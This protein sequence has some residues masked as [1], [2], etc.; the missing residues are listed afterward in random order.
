MKINAVV[1]AAILSASLSAAPQTQNTSLLRKAHEAYTAAQSLESELNE[2]PEG[3]RARADYLNVINAY[4]RVYLITPRTGYADNSLMNMARL[5]E[6]MHDNAAAIKTLKYLVHEYPSTPFKDT[7]E[8]DI[9]RLSGVKLQKTVSVD[10]VRYWEGQNSIR[11][12]VDV[13]G[14]VTFTQGD[15]KDPDRVFIDVSP[16]KLTSMLIGKQWPVK[17]PLL[18]QIRV[19]QYDNTTVRVVLDVGTFGRVATFTLRDPDRLVVDVLGKDAVPGKDAI[20]QAV[21]APQPAPAPVPT[22]QPITPPTKQP[23]TPTATNAPT[24]TTTSPSVTANVP[25]IDPPK[26][27]PVA[28]AVTKPDVPRPTTPPATTNKQSASTAKKTAEKKTAE[29]EAKAA[30]AIIPAKAPNEGQRSLVRSLGLK[31]SRVV[32]DAGH[33][34]HDTG[35]IGQGGYTE[36]ELVLDVAQRLKQLIETELGAEVIMTRSDDS[37]VPLESRTAIANQQQAD[38][39]ISIHANS[40]RV[41]SVRGVETYFLNFTSSREAL[42]TASRENAASE[43]SIHELQDL[44]KKIMLQDKVDESRE[45]AQHIERALAARKGS[46]IDRGVKQAPFVVL[47]GANMPSILAEVCFISNPQDEKT[48]KTV[49]NRQAIAESLFEGVRSY[50]DTLSGTKTAKTQDKTN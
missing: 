9:A 38:L 2:T 21:S 49:D 1:T 3:Q 48:V 8:K 40:S 10:N 18:Q 23:A 28:P 4:Q 32:I 44:V 45:L 29:P 36:K 46:G 26:P 24:T 16:A 19:G 12:I 50:A 5:F 6:E 22:T 30:A 31:L 11:I 7:A 41:R 43:R 47:I 20:T 17:S 34:G 27:M 33:G 42:E 37:F 39:F 35:T 14:E 25:P 15:A 13:G